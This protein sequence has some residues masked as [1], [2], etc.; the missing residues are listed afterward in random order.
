M[1]DLTNIL[2]ELDRQLLSYRKNH[3]TLEAQVLLLCFWSCETSGLGAVPLKKL[4]SFPQE[5]TKIRME[6]FVDRTN[7]GSHLRILQV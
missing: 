4:L 2:R 6:L 7:E 5:L 3:R 1:I